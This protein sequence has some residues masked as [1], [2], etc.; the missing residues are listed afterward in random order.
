MSYIDNNLIGNENVLYKGKVTLL[1]L[2]PWL[3]W[4]VIFIVPTAGVSLLLLPLGYILIRSNEAGITDKRVIAKTGLIR[5]DT[6]EISIDKVSSL[7]IKQGIFG[8]VFGYGSLIISDVGASRAPIKYI[9]DPMSF[10]RR[11]FE[12]QEDKK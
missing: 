7:Q 12:V 10:R 2:I 1:A 3:I 6:I 9:K 8:R 5:R 11:F 4:A